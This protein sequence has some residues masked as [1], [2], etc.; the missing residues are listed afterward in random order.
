MTTQEA[1]LRALNRLCKWRM[2]LVG[3]LIGTR[4]DD[5]VI[6]Q[7]YRDLFEKL[8]ILRA[9]K[10]A[11]VELLIKKGIVTESEFCEQLGQEAVGLEMEYQKR[12]PGIRATDSGLDFYDVEKV[13]E[14]MKNWPS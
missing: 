3:R 4:S 2:V 1:A 7:G 13:R 6:A 11:I 9:E 10:S 5:D 12:F 14:W 8:L